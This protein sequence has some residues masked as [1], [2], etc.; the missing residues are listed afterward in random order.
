M[1]Q[2]HYWTM[3]LTL[4]FGQPALPMVLSAQTYWATHLPGVLASLSGWGGPGITFN[5]DLAHDSA[6][7]WWLSL[8]SRKQT[9]LQGQ[10]DSSFKDT[11]QVG[12]HPAEFPGQ[13]MPLFWL[14]R[15]AKQLAGT[16]AWVVQG[17]GGGG[18]SRSRRFNKGGTL[19][20]KIQ[21][22]MIARPSPLF[23]HNPI[24]SGQALQIA[25]KLSWGKTGMGAPKKW[26]TCL[27]S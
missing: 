19:F 9:R 18:G 15:W 8:L 23:F 4:P 1:L 21:V 22:L 2:V 10:Q 26:P 11:Y 13:T 20:S 14:C 12:L 7:L 24:P 3:T 25:L 17:V 27:E 6:P 5:H 16:T